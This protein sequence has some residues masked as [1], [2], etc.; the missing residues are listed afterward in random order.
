MLA[1]DRT[2]AQIV[3]DHPSATLIG[4]GHGRGDG[5]VRYLKAAE[6]AGYMMHYSTTENELAEN[7]DKVEGIILA[8]VV[9]D[10]LP[11]SLRNIIVTACEKYNPFY[12]I[13]ISSFFGI[14]QET[15]HR[16]A[17]TNFCSDALSDS[18]A[19]KRTSDATYKAFDT[20]N[21]ESLN[22]KIRSFNH[23]GDLLSGMIRRF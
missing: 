10:F 5:Y 3:A 14:D 19:C 2:L 16:Y 1:L 6:D 8:L 13:H 12:L 9:Q 21:A 18:P 23:L 17:I 4:L 11:D 20:A 15:R 7:I 22:L